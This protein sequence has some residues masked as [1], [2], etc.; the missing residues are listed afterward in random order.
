MIFVSEFT[1][2]ING[3]RFALV[4]DQPSELSKVLHSS[5][6]D[7]SN[8]KNKEQSEGPS[9]KEKEEEKKN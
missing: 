6:S 8:P 5:Q 3:Q 4:E 7:R 1:I 9:G 2:L